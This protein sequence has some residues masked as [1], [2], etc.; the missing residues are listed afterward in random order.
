[1]ACLTFWDPSENR[2][3]LRE[4][5]TAAV[6]K[7]IS[8]ADV[9]DRSPEIRHWHDCRGRKETERL[10][11][12]TAFLRKHSGLWSLTIPTACIQA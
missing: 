9:A 11:A 5:P 12:Y 4:L 3:R 10:V 8:A 1:M 6:R 2:D 7:P